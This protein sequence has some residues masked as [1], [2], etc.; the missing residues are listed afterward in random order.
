MRISERD[1]GFKSVI[2]EVK[3]SSIALQASTEFMPAAPERGQD[4]HF[5]FMCQ[6]SITLINYKPT[7]CVLLTRKSEVDDDAK[8]PSVAYRYTYLS[9]L[10]CCQY[11]P[12]F[13]AGKAAEL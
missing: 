6:I 7:D 13:I 2:A 1:F 11:K 12:V 3:P 5:F 4:N 10:P 8:L 9:T